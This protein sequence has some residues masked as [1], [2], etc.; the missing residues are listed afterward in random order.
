MER[1][2]PLITVIIGVE[3]ADKDGKL[4][5]TIT[6]WDFQQLGNN[7]DII[8]SFGHQI[9][10]AIR[11]VIHNMTDREADDLKNLIKMELLNG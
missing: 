1:S 4:K 11:E 8:E 7:N 3:D 5:F 10:Y 9:S 6:P 2:Q